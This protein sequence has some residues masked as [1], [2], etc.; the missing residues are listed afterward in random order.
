MI[1]TI[2]YHSWNDFKRDFTKDLFP[3]NVYEKDCYIFRGQGEE[4]WHLKSYFQREFG[5]K[6]PWNIKE[7]MEKQLLIS[8]KANCQRYLDEDILGNLNEEELMILAQ[9]YHVP[10]TLLDWSYSPYIAAFFAFGQ[11]FSTNESQNI[12]I[13]ALKKNHQIWNDRNGAKI[14]ENLIPV[15]RRQRWQ[16]GCF[17]Q[18]EYAEKSVD[19]YALDRKIKDPSINIDDAI[20]KFTIPKSERL[21]ALAELEAMNITYPV[22]LG[23]IES[24]GNAAILDVQMKYFKS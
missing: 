8:F 14:I 2:K 4:S 5:E 20:I 3:D 1:K 13:W 17:T 6:I 23:G 9:H 24:C 18:I 21:Q 12:A 11:C 10:T 19:D 16:Q 22:I 15:N 7:E